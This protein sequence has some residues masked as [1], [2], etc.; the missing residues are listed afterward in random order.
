MFKNVCQQKGHIGLISDQYIKK[1]KTTMGKRLLSTGE[2]A[3]KPTPS[4]RLT[5]KVGSR[6]V[7]KYI[8]TKT[9]QKG[10]KALTIHDLAAIEGD[11]LI[12]VKDEKGG[13]KEADIEAGETVA[14]F[15]SYMIDQALKQVKPGETVEFVFTGVKSLANG[16]KLNEIDISIIED[17]A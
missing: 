8:G 2:G 16:N 11:A 15:G 14:M 9:V 6:F 12:T 7:G 10:K 5:E 1:E 3:V 4:V 13:Y 17:E